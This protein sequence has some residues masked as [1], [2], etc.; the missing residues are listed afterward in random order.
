[1]VRSKEN[2]MNREKTDIEIA[3]SWCIK[4]KILVYP[5]PV[6]ATTLKIEVDF[7]G[8][9]N[10]GDTI[11]QSKPKKKDQKWYE[12]ID[13]IYLDYHLRLSSPSRAQPTA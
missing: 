2:D 5:V 13:E 7:K 3:K 9:L 4:N 10:L 6:T 11:F 8:K 1:M 12:V